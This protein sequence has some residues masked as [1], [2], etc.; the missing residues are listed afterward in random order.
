MLIP[1]ITTANCAVMNSERGM[2]KRSELKQL[3]ALPWLEIVALLP[4]LPFLAFPLLLLATGL[5]AAAVIYPWHVVSATCILWL[6]WLGVTYGR[7]DSSFMKH[8]GR[9]SLQSSC[10]AALCGIVLGTAAALAHGLLE[11]HHPIYFNSRQLTN[12][13]Q[14]ERISV[15]CGRL[16]QLETY[17]AWVDTVPSEATK[18]GVLAVWLVFTRAKLLYCLRNR[19]LNHSRTSS[20]S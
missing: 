11:E 5:F 6:L 10:V 16:A 1:V 4:L 7:S 19:K 9:V 13:D 12:I 8:S 20:V 2:K 18:G 3:S 14:N 17:K 15:L